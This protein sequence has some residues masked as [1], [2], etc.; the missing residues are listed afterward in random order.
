MHFFRSYTE[1]VW[2]ISPRDIQADWAA[3]RIKNLSLPKAVWNALTKANDTSSLIE[4]FDYPRLGPGMMW[5][6][7]RDLIEERGGRVHM[8]A[9]VVKLVRESSRI[10]A[11]H[12]EKEGGTERVPGTDFINSMDLRDLNDRIEPAPPAEVVAAAHRLRYRDF[13]IVGLIVDRSDPFPDNWV[14]VHSQSVKVGR[15]QNFRAWSRDM[16]PSDDQ[17][18]I[19]MEYFCQEGD[20]LW[21]TPDDELIALGSRELEALGLASAEEVSDG[22]VIRQRKAYPVYDTQY[23]AAVD[24]IAAWI[25]GLENFQTVGRNGLH[26]YNNQD[27]SMLTAILAAQNLV[28][29]DHDVWNVNVERSYHE[30][31]ERKPEPARAAA[32]S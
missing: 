8:D 32:A 17:S 10:V 28:G 20:G 23:L 14:Y 22:T 29:A 16:V 24:T 1:K 15:T 13:L 18:F 7:A 9:P 11:V 30:E 19:G 2:G 6:R 3:Q 21:N 4:E 12:V 25:G 26:R 5:E 27:H 31:F